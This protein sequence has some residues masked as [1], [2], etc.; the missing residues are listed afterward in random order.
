MK[1]KFQCGKCPQ[2]SNPNPFRIELPISEELYYTFI[3]D[4]G[5]ENKY[6]VANTRFGLLFESGLYAFLDGYNR[7]AVSS[8]YVALERFYEHVTT[9]FLLYENQ[10]SFEE[11]QSL[12]K[13]IYLSERS[14]GAFCTIYLMKFRKP[15]IPFDSKQFLNEINVKFTNFENSPVKFRNKII[16]EGYIPNHEETLSY[17][18]VVGGFISKITNE[19]IAIDP[20]AFLNFARMN[21]N[22]KRKQGEKNHDHEVSNMVFPTFLGNIMNRQPNK[23][24]IENHIEFIK[25]NRAK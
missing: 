22:H 9:M 7:E 8:Y 15:L 19:I 24:E 5:H 10:F 13:T 11:I 18:K 4:R 2:L 25:L 14:Y 23:Y 6:T 1:L 12:K 3:C 21:T 16:H 20:N 17:A